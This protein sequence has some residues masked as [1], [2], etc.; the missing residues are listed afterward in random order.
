M[1]SHGTK[2]KKPLCQVLA[3]GEHQQ[4]VKLGTT[5]KHAQPCGRSV[6]GRKN[7]GSLPSRDTHRQCQIN[8]NCPMAIPRGHLFGCAAAANL[9]R[10]SQ[11][12]GSWEEQCEPPKK[13]R[14]KKCKR[15]KLDFLDF[16]GMGCDSENMLFGQKKSTQKSP[17]SIS[18]KIV[19]KQPNT[20]K[21]N[22]ANLEKGNKKCACVPF[23]LITAINRCLCFVF[24]ANIWTQMV[25]KIKLR[26][27][28]QF[29]C[30]CKLPEEITNITKKS[31]TTA[32]DLSK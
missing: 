19:G 5:Q 7:W 27:H 20:K 28:V 9:E 15:N 29:M 4:M 14:H 26:L 16:L 18:Q 3:K 6:A 31:E 17:L 13:T 12:P 24:L 22:A 32:K 8:P 30:I 2:H 10:H 23:S 25:Y 11:H 21:A 1:I